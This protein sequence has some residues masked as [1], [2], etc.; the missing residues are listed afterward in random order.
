LHDSRPGQAHHNE[1]KE[2]NQRNCEQT[3]AGRSDP[4]ERHL[5]PVCR[6]TAP[7]REYPR[8]GNAEGTYDDMRYPDHQAYAHGAHHPP[9]QAVEDGVPKNPG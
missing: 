7:R 1:T 6:G 8:N 2:R 4:F 5:T 9:R 3:Q